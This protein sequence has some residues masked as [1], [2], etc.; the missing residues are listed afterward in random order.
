ML[1]NCGYKH[2][3]GYYKLKESS[4]VSLSSPDFCR[5]SNE[6]R[7]EVLGAC[8]S[9]GAPLDSYIALRFC[10]RTKE[11][12]IDSDAFGGASYFYFC[13]VNDV[14]FFSTS[15]SRLLAISSINP[16]LNKSSLDDF[17]RHGFI[18]NNNTLINKVNKLLPTQ[19]LIIYDKEISIINKQPY[20][21]EEHK[22]GGWGETFINQESRILGTYIKE[23]DPQKEYGVS[24]SSGFDSNLILHYVLENRC[25]ATIVS[26]G[27]N[28][29]SSE[30]EDVLT[31][32]D[33][34]NIENRRLSYVT[35]ESFVFFK[36]IVNRLEGSVFEPGIFLQYELAK[37]ASMNGINNMLC[38][39]CADQ[40]FNEE[41]YSNFYFKSE[42]YKFGKNPYELASALIIKKSGIMLNSF[43]ISGLY[44]YCTSGMIELGSQFR[45]E[46]GRTKELHK[47]CCINKVQ[48]RISEL[49]KKRG[50]STSLEALFKTEAEKKEFVNSVKHDSV[51]KLISTECTQRF[52]PNYDYDLLNALCIHYLEIF[53]KLYCCK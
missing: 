35:P 13:N 12:Y 37:K 52:G 21:S 39:E 7:Y 47:K 10:E 31:I 16:E 48:S 46:N 34:Y 45:M 1:E 17:V 28:N 32:C 4:L 15:L 11:L 24:L 44:P 20:I 30:I 36:D 43:G 51:Y 53:Y 40:I 26:V 14:C 25:N 50:G 33:I 6:G 9:S 38:G 18:P 8:D 2:I 22:I 49:L 19:H 5:I 3:S 27:E 42:N 41:F 29:E 23:L